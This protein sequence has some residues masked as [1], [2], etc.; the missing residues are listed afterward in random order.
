MSSMSDRL[1]DA[2]NAFKEL[3]SK[4]NEVS[5]KIIHLGDQLERKNAPRESLQEARRLI[6]EFSK[7]LGAGGGTFSNIA[8]NSQADEALVRLDQI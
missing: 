8:V 3:D 4:I 7:F 5:G 2:N 1:S 6:L